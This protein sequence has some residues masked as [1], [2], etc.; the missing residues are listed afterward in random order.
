MDL[1]AV[2][3][4]PKLKANAI[5][6]KTKL[7]IH[8]FTMY[9][10]ATKEVTC[11]WFSEIDADLLASTF[12][13]LIKHHL[14][15]VLKVKKLPI[16]LFSDGCCY[17][18]RNVILSNILLKLSVEQGVEIVQKYLQVGHTHSSI[19]R[20]LENRDIFCHANM[21][22]HIAKEAR[23][24]SNPYESKQLHFSFFKDYSNTAQFV[25]KS[26]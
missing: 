2:K 7:A 22:V 1:Q 5:Y 3:L 4:C 25:Y 14:E 9:N 10:M 23:T 24:N 18:N 19:E 13:S 26:I 6:Y 16:I 20:K 21:S 12:V 15:E 17:Q 8:N 11:Y